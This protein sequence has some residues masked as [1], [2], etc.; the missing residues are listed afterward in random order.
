[1]KIE[2]AQTADLESE[3]AGLLALPARHAPPAARQPA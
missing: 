2:G 3:I 1:M